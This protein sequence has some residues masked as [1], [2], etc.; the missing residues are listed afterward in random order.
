MKLRLPYLLC[1]VLISAAPAAYAKDMATETPA[2]NMP[3]KAG[4]ERNEVKEAFA[5]WRKTLS[6]GDA[7]AI[8]ALYK[9]DAVLAA[10]LS[11]EPI[12][13]QKN[14]TIYFEGLIKKKDLAVKLDK[15]FIRIL[16]ENDAAVSGTYTFS[17]KDEADKTVT[18]PARFTYVFQKNAEGKWLI[19]EHH[20]SKFP[21]DK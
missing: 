5:H 14:R 19:A 18:V 4:N 17:F 20:S 16:D 7:A 8:V 11:N 15:E 12:T 21:M 2:I 13:N 3:V 6:G 1:S 9:A 10:T